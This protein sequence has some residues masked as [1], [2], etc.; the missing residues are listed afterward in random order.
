MK[1]G[2]PSLRSSVMAHR[3]GGNAA[4]HFS[5]TRESQVVTNFQG[6]EN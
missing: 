4:E 5:P 3:P 6:D 1:Q 2:L